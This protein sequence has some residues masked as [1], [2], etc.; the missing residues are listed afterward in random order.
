M[1]AKQ[2]QLCVPY[3]CLFI[4]QICV[5]IITEVGGGITLFGRVI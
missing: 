4:L 3:G 5:D 1:I 2:V